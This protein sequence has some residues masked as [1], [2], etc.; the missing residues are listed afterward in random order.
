MPEHTTPDKLTEG[1]IV[2]KRSVVLFSKDMI[3][4]FH[5]P[6][7]QQLGGS[8]RLLEKFYNPKRMFIFINLAFIMLLHTLV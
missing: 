5:T 8:L 6:G 7:I 1:L 4:V 2:G 3:N